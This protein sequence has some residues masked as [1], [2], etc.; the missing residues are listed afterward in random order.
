MVDMGQEDE[1]WVKGENGSV[2]LPIGRES[3][4]KRKQNG[5]GNEK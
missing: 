1:K 5:Q 3:G 2:S 4:S